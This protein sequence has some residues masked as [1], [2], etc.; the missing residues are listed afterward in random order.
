MYRAGSILQLA[1]CLRTS[2][3]IRRTSFDKDI[4]HREMT[5]VV[6]KQRVLMN[7][8]L[9]CPIVKHS[10]VFIRIRFILRSHMAITKL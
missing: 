4:V 8:I 7:C 6:E 2:F 9:F 1:C 5:T 3:D 10:L